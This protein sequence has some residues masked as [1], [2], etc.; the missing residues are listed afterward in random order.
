MLDYKKL[1]TIVEVVEKNKCRKHPKKFID[2]DTEQECNTWWQLVKH[3]T[4]SDTF[5]LYNS[6]R[7]GAISTPAIAHLSLHILSSNFKA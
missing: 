2:V 6:G 7:F 4:D 5:L 1:S 3:E